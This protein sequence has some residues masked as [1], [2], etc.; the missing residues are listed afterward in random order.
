V[1]DDNTGR[2]GSW[3][4]VVC[5]A[6]GPLAALCVYALGISSW[7]HAAAAT[8]AVGVWMAIWWITEAIP[9]PATALLPIV[10]LPVLGTDAG[11]PRVGQVVEITQKA[12]EDIKPTVTLLG[13][14]KSV[15]EQEVVVISSDAQ[16]NVIEQPLPL[17]RVQSTQRSSPIQAAT[18]PFGDSNIFLYMG[19]FILALAV[20]KWGL[21]RR[22][23]IGLMLWLGT[24]GA[25]ILL[26]MMLA[27]AIL[28]MWIS[29]TAATTIMLPIALGICRWLD[30]GDSE[31]DSPSRS[32]REGSAASMLLLSIAYAATIGGMATTI[33]T[34]TN[35]VA[36]NVLKQQGIEITSR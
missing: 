14:V 24:S 31:T 6:A 16:G 36:L 12:S 2:S 34:P 22:F 35:G 19:G 23:A 9:L 29:N 33:G 3:W 15:S 32:N 8:A 27:T 4:H 28:S 30:R 13:K 7:P 20:E 1:A 18:A 21:H 5:L 17:D 11:R 26:G 10:L 25:S